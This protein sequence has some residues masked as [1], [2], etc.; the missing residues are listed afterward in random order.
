MEED[1]AAN[2][3]QNAGAVPGGYTGNTVDSARY[4]TFRIG[5]NRT[6]LRLGPVI[7]SS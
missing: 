7:A 3:N 5:P 2:A 4:A 6:R 1:H